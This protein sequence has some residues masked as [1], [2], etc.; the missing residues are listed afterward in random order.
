MCGARRTTI[1][2]VQLAQTVCQTL[3][4]RLSS[5]PWITA[6]NPSQ[7]HVVG[8]RAANGLVTQ[9][10]SNMHLAV[11]RRARQAPFSDGQHSSRSSNQQQYQQQPT[12]Q[13][14][15]RGFS[16]RFD[17][18]RTKRKPQSSVT[19]P[20]CSVRGPRC[21][22]DPPLLSRPR[23]Q[24]TCWTRSTRADWQRSTRR[25][26]PAPMPRRSWLGPATAHSLRP[27]VD[28]PV[29]PLSS[30]R[31]RVGGVDKMLSHS[32]SHGHLRSVRYHSWPSA[33]TCVTCYVD[34]DIWHQDHADKQAELKGK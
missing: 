33:C 14:P 4:S 26:G 25:S 17:W 22:S 6:W 23:A 3:E 19:A 2:T 10:A 24:R 15:S 5:L 28:R 31:A 34:T 30:P 8:R 16:P 11:P 13:P 27:S 12:H 7:K 20:I 1:P 21:P 29:S 18:T 32:L 9:L